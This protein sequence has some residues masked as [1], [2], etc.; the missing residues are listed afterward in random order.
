MA[1][2]ASRAFSKHAIGTAVS[3]APIWP[4]PGRRQEMP[5]LITGVMPV[6]T[7]LRMS[8]PSG[9]PRKFSVGIL[10]VL[11][12]ATVISNMFIVV[13]TANSGVPPTYCTTAGAPAIASEPRPRVSVIAESPMSGL[14]SSGPKPGK[15]TPLICGAGA[16]NQRSPVPLTRIPVS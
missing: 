5:V 9:V 15:N 13:C 3:P 12:S 6:F 8:M 2:K 11:F 14:A 1:A 16:V 7:T 4:T 10:K